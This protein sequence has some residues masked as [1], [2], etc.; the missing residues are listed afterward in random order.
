[1]SVFLSFDYGTK[2]I[3]VG[4]GDDITRTARALSTVRPDWA[5]LGKLIADWQPNAFVVGLPL[6][7]DGEEQTI[8]RAAREFA[9][10]LG[11]RYKK[12]VHFCDERYSSVAA[13]S[14]LRAQRASGERK[15][16]LKATDEDAEAARQILEQFL[17]EH[18]T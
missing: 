15:H 12:P 16:R 17:N 11:E 18:A 14:S 13:Q 5:L 9:R 1:M 4:V 3:G 7:K 2:K 6:G 8:T 10:T